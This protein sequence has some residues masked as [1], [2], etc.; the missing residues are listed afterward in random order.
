MLR[1]PFDLLG[2]AA[3][4]RRLLAQAGEAPARDAGDAP[5]AGP[6]DG[7]DGAGGAERAAGC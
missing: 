2:F 4:I 7:A 1:K 3:I 5:G 6:S